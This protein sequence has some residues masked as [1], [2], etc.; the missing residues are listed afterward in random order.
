MNRMDL[1]V[2]IGVVLADVV[3]LAELLFFICRKMLIR[4]SQ[5]KF[6]KL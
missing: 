5:R 1:L 3:L 2:F 4:A 6:D